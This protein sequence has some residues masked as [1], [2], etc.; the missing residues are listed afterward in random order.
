M[1]RPI[2]ITLVVLAVVA[3]VEIPLTLLYV[4]PTDG[5]VSPDVRSPLPMLVIAAVVLGLGARAHSPDRVRRWLRARDVAV[6][7]DTVAAAGAWLDRTVLWRSIGF[8]VPLTLQLTSLF[9]VNSLAV[10]DPARER[11]MDVMNLL[12]GGFFGLSIVGYALAAVL[13]ELS[14]ARRAPADVAVRAADLRDRTL[15]A[16]ANPVSLTL[17]RALGVVAVVL[18]A[19][20]VL[21]APGSTHGSA[22]ELVVGTAVVLLAVEA[23]RHHVVTRRQQGHDADGLAV[24]DAARVTT[25]H[26]VSGS[27]IALLALSLSAHVDVLAFALDGR[28]LNPLASLAGLLAL[29]GLGIWF[30]H[31]IELAHT[32]RRDGRPSGRDGAERREQAVA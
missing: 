3:A 22:L 7:D 13:A 23:V 32:R 15:A 11:A 30:G 28:W 6:T 24:D 27:A 20:T 16:Y 1:W 29:A 8:A 14:R 19:T 17:P 4:G 21:L 5:L 31:G 25:V 10:N 26:A 2:R 9:L 18:A 12:T